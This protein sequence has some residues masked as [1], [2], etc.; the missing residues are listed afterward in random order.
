MKIALS[1]V[2]LKE[3]S[4]TQVLGLHSQA[5]RIRISETGIQRLSLKSNGWCFKKKTFRGEGQGMT[6]AKIGVKQLQAKKCQRLPAGTRD[7]CHT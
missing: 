4:E 7:R 5:W 1:R 3:W 6:E 2:V